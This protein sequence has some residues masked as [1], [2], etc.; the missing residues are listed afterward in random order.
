VDSAPSGYESGDDYH[1]AINTA[2]ARAEAPSTSERDLPPASP[3]RNRQG[4]TVQ[5]NLDE[6]AEETIDSAPSGYESADEYHDAINAA[7]ARAEAPTVPEAGSTSAA[8]TPQNAPRQPRTTTTPVQRAFSREA[9]DGND[10]IDVDVENG[11]AQDFNAEVGQRPTAQRTVQR[12]AQ[13]DLAEPEAESPSSNSYYPAGYDS[14]DSYQAAISAAIQRAEAPTPPDAPARRGKVARKA[15][16]T[17]QRTGTNSPARRG[18]DGAHATDG[19]GTRGVFLT[20]AVMHEPPSLEDDARAVWAG[21]PYAVQRD[22]DG[23]ADDAEAGGFDSI[24]DIAFNDV[25]NSLQRTPSAEVYDGGDENDDNSS[26]EG[27]L[28]QMLGLPPDTPIARSTTPQVQRAPIAEANA[29]DAPPPG[30]VQRAQTVALDAPRAMTEHGNNEQL[31]DK[32]SPEKSEQ[33][34]KVAQAVYSRLRDRLKVER[35]R[36]RGRRS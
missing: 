29:T 3:K 28:L 4:A 11:A 36:L 31:G 25:S 20:G 27:E 19:D 9:S 34:E 33:I 8:T 2:I 1:D 23:M 16:S 10:D 18:A 14:A 22:Y 32:L 24:D 13:R 7:I 26:V 6:A 21:Q 17:V 15:K 5:R 12:T 35:E 30:L